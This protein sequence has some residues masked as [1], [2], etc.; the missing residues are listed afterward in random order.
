M[1]QAYWN[2]PSIIMSQDRFLDRVQMLAL[3]FEHNR[4]NP[5]DYYR[6]EVNPYSSRLIIFNF[7]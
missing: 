3:Q 2:G 7:D 1:A 5:E 4:N 6:R